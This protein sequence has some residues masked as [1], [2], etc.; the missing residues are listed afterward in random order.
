MSPDKLNN[1]SSEPALFKPLKSTIC[2][3]PSSKVMVKILVAG[4]IVKSV[5]CWSSVLSKYGV[6]S[7]VPPSSNVKI[8]PDKLNNW[9]SDPALFKP[10]KSTI[11][12]PPS[13][14]VSVKILVA[15][16][17]VKSVIC[18]SSVLSKYGVK[19]TVPPSSSVKMSPDKLNNWSSDPALFKPLK[20]T[21]WVPPSSKVSV[22][23]LVAGSIVKSVICWS[24]VLSKYGVK[25]TV[26]PSSNVK[27][28]P[29]KLNNWSSDPALF[30]PLKSTIWVPPSS[31]VI[32]NM[33]VTG[34]IAKFVICWSSV[35]SKYGVKSTVCAVAFSMF[36]V[37]TLVTGSISN[38]VN[39]WS[40]VAGSPAGPVRS[41]VVN[42][43]PSVKLIVNVPSPFSVTPVTPT[44]SIPSK[45]SMPLAPLGPVRLGVV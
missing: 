37:S 34:S 15:G 22:K 1:W 3:P 36:I 4:S 14:K 9:S 40:S 31:N 30:K 12:V 16:S 33:F 24:S 25:S 38:W 35:L 41:I 42:C 7:T 6:K 23:I 28:S 20:S 21:I 27:M 2:V 13:S 29:D 17:I 5:I 45:P 19:S 18:W 43:V 39:C 8:S 10:L 32:V 44:P 26:P 11:W